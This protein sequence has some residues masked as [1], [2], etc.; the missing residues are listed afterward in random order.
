MTD[1][2]L[3]TEVS[4]DLSEP[5]PA[6]SLND[7]LY[8]YAKENPEHAANISNLLRT[9]QRQIDELDRHLRETRRELEATR[10]RY[11]ELYDFAPIGYFTLDSGQAGNVVGG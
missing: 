6:F 2:Q 4:P 10:S 9:Q 8:D 1:D 11:T 5:D 7:I 3:P